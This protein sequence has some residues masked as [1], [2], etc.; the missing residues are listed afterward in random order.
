MPRKKKTEET[1]DEEANR[2]ALD[3]AA[4]VVEGK[5]SSLA[6][7]PA[8]RPANAQPLVKADTREKL[9]YKIACEG[10]PL[11]DEFFREFPDMKELLELA[12]VISAR[13]MIVAVCNGLMPPTQRISAIRVLA[14]LAGKQVPDEEDDKFKP[15]PLA[16]PRG[17][18]EEVNATLEKIRQLSTDTLSP[19]L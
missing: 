13:L 4:G 2:R 5:R 18:K 6:P 7:P 12:L 9:L 17:S 19:V 14:S 11:G 10:A 1:I 3:E 8:T 16:I 15:A